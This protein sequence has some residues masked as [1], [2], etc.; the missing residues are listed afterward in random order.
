MMTNRFYNV[1]GSNFNTKQLFDH[2]LLLN[3]P[4][5][6]LQQVKQLSKNRLQNISCEIQFTWRLSTAGLPSLVKIR[7]YILG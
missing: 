1:T 6:V 7:C 3:I 5:E 4:R 2:C